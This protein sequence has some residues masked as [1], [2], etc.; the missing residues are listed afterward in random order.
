[1]DVSVAGQ[2]PAGEGLIPFQNF[3]ARTGAFGNQAGGGD[4]PEKYLGF[5]VCF[6]LTAGDQAEV[7]R[8]RTIDA[9]FLHR[10]R[11]RDPA[12]AVDP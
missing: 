2:Q 12:R 7:E 11:Q 10:A 4:V 9:D 3:Y 5:K 6:G 1:M 8:G